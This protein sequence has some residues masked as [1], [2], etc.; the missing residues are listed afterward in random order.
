MAKSKTVYTCTECGGQS[1]KWQGQ[2]PH[3]QDWNTLVETIVESGTAGTHRY[4]A[5]ASGSGERGIVQ[6]LSN[7]N[8]E[9]VPR[10]RPPPSTRSNSAMPVVLRGTSS[11]FTLERTCT[12]PRSPE[13]LANAA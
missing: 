2:C 5:L 9:D 10:T 1:T 8:P 7:V 4:A 3:C 12:M 13:P 11:G 6:V